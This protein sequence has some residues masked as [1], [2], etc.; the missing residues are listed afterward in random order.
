LG[1]RKSRR[2]YLQNGEPPGRKKGGREIH[3]RRWGVFGKKKR[4]VRSIRFPKGVGENGTQD[5]NK[6]GGSG[7]DLT[8][9]PRIQNKKKPGVLWGEEN[10][11]QKQGEKKLREKKK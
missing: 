1:G 2:E 11:K 7:R 3:R 5:W 8:A 9:S 6:G 10:P 4:G